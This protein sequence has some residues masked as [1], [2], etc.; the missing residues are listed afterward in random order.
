MNLIGVGI[1]VW[2]IPYSK[3]HN[4]GSRV[5]LSHPLATVTVRVEGQNHQQCCAFAQGNCNRRWRD[6]RFR[7]SKSNLRGDVRLVFLFKIHVQPVAVS[8]AS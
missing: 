3:R 5:D 4:V 8:K 2:K 7:A 6:T 1:K